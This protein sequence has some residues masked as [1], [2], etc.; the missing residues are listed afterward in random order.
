LRLLSVLLCREDWFCRRG[1]GQRDVLASIPLVDRVVLPS[2]G[3]AAAAAA[4]G[5]GEECAAVLG[6]VIQAVAFCA[7]CSLQY[8]FGSGRLVFLC[9]VPLQLVIVT[10]LDLK[11][12]L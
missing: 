11:D 9:R 4:V 5:V 12:W 1:S 2:E 8:H 3:G 10:L 6:G 7:M